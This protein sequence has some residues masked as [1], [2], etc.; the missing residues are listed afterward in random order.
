[1]LHYNIPSKLILNKLHIGLFNLPALFYEHMLFSSYF[2]CIHLYMQ[3]YKHMC[4][5]HALSVTF[6]YKYKHLK[7]M[8]G[9]TSPI[10]PFAEYC[11]LYIAHFYILL[12]ISVHMCVISYSNYIRN[13]I[14]LTS[15][16]LPCSCDFCKIK[17]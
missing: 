12:I 6:S 3:L 17:E 5:F 14:T 15:F 8:N 9:S 1:M 10:I 2:F 4:N 11:I 7:S 16:A 13:L